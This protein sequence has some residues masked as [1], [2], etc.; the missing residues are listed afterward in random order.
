MAT[1]RLDG[2]RANEI[3]AAASGE[4]T[5]SADHELA[6]AGVVIRPGIAQVKGLRAP[7][8]RRVQQQRLERMSQG[9]GAFLKSKAE[10]KLRDCKIAL[11]AHRLVDGLPN[12]LATMV[13]GNRSKKS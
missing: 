5:D 1:G 9:L 7:S 10:L 12:Q 2:D 6:G 11:A 4:I 3:R 8:F 13:L